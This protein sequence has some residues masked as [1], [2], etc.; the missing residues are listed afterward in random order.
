MDQGAIIRGTGLKIQLKKY[1]AKMQ[2]LD[3]KCVW[4]DMLEECLNTI[5][6]YFRNH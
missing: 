2:K 4:V 6:I 1:Y 5:Q 3:A